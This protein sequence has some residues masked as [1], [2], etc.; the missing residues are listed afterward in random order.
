MMSK[1]TYPKKLFVS[2]CIIFVTESNGD[3]VKIVIFL[4]FI[5]MVLLE[6]FLIKRKKNTIVMPF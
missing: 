1:T 6:M 2:H 3:E 4:D 5:Q